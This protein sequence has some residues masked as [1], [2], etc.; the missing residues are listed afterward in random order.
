MKDKGSAFYKFAKFITA[1]YFTTV[2][3]CKYIGRENVPTEGPVVIVCNHISMIDPILLGGGCKR[4]VN[5]MA[6]DSLFKNKFI[7]KVL[8]GLGAFPVNRGTG[9]TDA[10]ASAIKILEDDRMLGIF[11]EGTRSK[12]GTLGKPKTGATMLA[13]KTNATF[14]PVAITVDGGTLPKAFKKTVIRYGKP[15]SLTDVGMTEDTNMHYRKGAKALMSHISELRDNSL[16][17]FTR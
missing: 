3:R 10:L 5:Y 16:S 17:E 8:L 7:A 1:V 2:F 15:L 14:V 12:D 6:K 11:I 4:Q 9:A 13:S